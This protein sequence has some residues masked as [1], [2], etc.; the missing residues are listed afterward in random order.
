MQIYRALI[1]SYQTSRKRGVDAEFVLYRLYRPLSFP[2]S[3]LLIKLGFSANQ[4]TA[5]GLFVLLVSASALAAG[6]YGWTVVGAALF[7]LAFILDFA[8]G[9]IAR[10]Q[11][12]PSIFGKLVDGLVDTL[13]CVIFVAAAA[14]NTR[15]SL[16]LLPGDIEVVLGL[17]T[18]FASLFG[19]YYRLRV[20]YFLKESAA[21]VDQGA[22]PIPGVTG[23][24]G[25]IA[26]AAKINKNLATSTPIVLIVLAPFGLLSLF[27]LFFFF[28]HVIVGFA[29]I[30]VSLRRLRRTLNVYRAY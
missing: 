1:G 7:T 13:A 17:L 21:A 19:N 10:F 18:A 25:V 22:G 6:T 16:N 11:E 12:K 27:T 2:V 29:E 8:D 14:G 26:W 24:D 15:A 28:I 20:T 30:V 23:N 9:N 4:V 3:A 5:L